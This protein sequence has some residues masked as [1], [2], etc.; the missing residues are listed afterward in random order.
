VILPP[1]TLAVLHGW[2]RSKQ[3]GAR[4][5]QDYVGRAVALPAQLPEAE[6]EEIVELFALFAGLPV[7][8]AAAPEG[9]PAGHVVVLTEPVDAVPR[10]V[11]GSVLLC[12]VRRAS[13]ARRLEASRELRLLRNAVVDAVGLQHAGTPL[14]AIAAQG[15]P[16]AD[17]PGLALRFASGAIG[18]RLADRGASDAEL[19][20]AGLATTVGWLLRGIDVRVAQWVLAR[21][22]PGDHPERL[23]DTEAAILG[24]DAALGRAFAAGL[25]ERLP[26]EPGDALDLRRPFVVLGHPEDRPAEA[27]LAML[28]RELRAVLA[29]EV[30]VVVERRLRSAPRPLGLSWPDRPRTFVGRGEVLKRLR[31]LFSPSDRVATT[32]LYG[33][34]GSGRTAVASAFCEIMTGTLEP[35]WI[36]FAGGPSSGWVP[37]ADAL[38]LDVGELQRSDTGEGR[39]PLWV[40]RI[41]D[42]LRDRACL[43][44][45]SDADEVPEEDMPAW[46]PS[47]PG[48]CAVLVL[49]RSAERPLQRENDA[50][51]VP[52]RALSLEESK[53]LLAARAPAKAEA[54]RAGEADGLLRVLDGHPG[55][56]VLAAGLL[57]KQSLAEVEALARGREGPVRA[58]AEKAAWALDAEEKKLVAALAV[59]APEGSPPALPLGIAEVGEEVLTRLADKALV[60]RRGR[61]VKLHGLIRLAIERDLEEERERLERA[62]AEKAAEAFEAAQEAGAVGAEDDA[63]GDALLALER[64][65]LKCRPGEQRA[66]AVVVRLAGTFLRYPRGNRAEHLHRAVAGYRA[67]LTVYTKDDAP[68]PWCQVQTQLGIA[69][70]ALPVGNKAENLRQAI[71]A[72]QA[73]A[74]VWTKEE[75]PEDWAELQHNIGLVLAALPTGDKVE[76]LQKAIGAHQTALAVWT[77]ES[78]PEKWAMAQNYLGNALRLL[79]TGDRAENLRR[80]IEAYHAA[81][82]VRTRDRFPMEWASVKN[83]LG[84]ALSSLLTGSRA[85]N[86]RQAIE[87]YRAALT[88]LTKETHPWEWAMVQNNLGNAFAMLPTGDKAE[89]I[90]QAIEAYRGALSV[91]TRS[92]FPWE[93][94]KTSYNF[95]LALVQLSSGNRKQNLRD[96]IDAFRDALTVYTPE[97]FPD[98]H[99]STQAALD[100]A[101]RDLATLEDPP[102]APKSKAVKKKKERGRRGSTPGRAR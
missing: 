90:H 34:L 9:A 19:F 67:A 54:V 15:R 74:T 58:L 96:A 63:Y 40:R 100:A 30:Y 2:P 93:W 12:V 42:L 85:N 70:R 25:V 11:E 10:G 56:L 14:Q 43:V 94:A 28:A 45:V 17:S 4:L 68:E 64:M 8:V 98:E 47:G 88:V 72:F 16:V 60:E 69:L 37:V 101:L 79:R 95:G 27:D 61:L 80:A 59:C 23:V 35:V 3:V 29:P 31:S 84:N 81:L 86:L 82:T 51:A 99:A 6:R 21:A 55:A 87:A 89:N 22:L 52:L 102:P 49:A 38:G 5:A 20:A 32:V 18:R 41:H 65:T 77:R 71:E 76:N 48:R 46:L 92:A 73:A 24:E 50:I 75:R 97:A 1:L 13:G 78:Y 66:A 26:D 39:V 62:H 7:H 53:E 83:N 36:T 44:V 57:E 91:R 33:I